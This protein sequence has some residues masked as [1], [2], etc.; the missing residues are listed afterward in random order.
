MCV[1]SWYTG[2]VVLM[3]M[4]LFSGLLLDLDKLPTFLWGLQYLSIV[5]Y[6]FHA[7]MINEYANEIVKC[8]RH[9]TCTFRTGNAVLSYVGT[10][11]TELGFNM[12]MLFVFILFYRAVAYVAL[13]YHSTRI[14][15]V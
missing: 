2:A 14:H 1:S 3:P 15:S 11:P 8:G 4:A 12:G 13:N 7:I 9:L 10:G 5:K 6:G